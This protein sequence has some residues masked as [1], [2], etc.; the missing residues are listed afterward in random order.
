MA[1]NCSN[2]GKRSSEVK[3]GGNAEFY[4]VYAVVNMHVIKSTFG[5][6]EIDKVTGH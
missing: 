3:S 6:R 2:C 4:S 1:T 5:V